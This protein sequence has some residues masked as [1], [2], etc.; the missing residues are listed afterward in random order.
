MAAEFAAV[1]AVAWV[2]WQY[3]Y[4]F[5]AATGAMT[6]KDDVDLGKPVWR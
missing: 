1:A 4:P 6:D 3:P 2:G 5:A